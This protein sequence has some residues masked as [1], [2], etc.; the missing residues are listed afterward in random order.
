MKSLSVMIGLLCLFTMN[1]ETAHA[2]SAEAFFKRFQVVRSPDG[3]LIGI[4]DRTLPVKFAVAPYVKQVREQLLDEQSLMNREGL[5]SGKYDSEVKNLLEE[6]MDYSFS[7]NQSDI[8]QNVE[9]VVDSLKKLAVLNVDFIFSHA[10]FQDVV[11][12]FQGKMSDAIMMLDPTMI[13]NVNDSTYFYKRNVTYK[14]VTWGLDFARKSM[15]NLPMLNTVS[16]V[17]VQVEKLITERRQFHQNMLLHYLENFKEEELGLTHD[18]VNMIWSSIYESRIPWYAIWESNAAKADWMKYG[19]NNF[20]AN[21]RAATANLKNAQ[22]LY[23]EVGDRMNFAFQKVTFNNEKVLVNLFDKEGM[24]QNRPAVAYNYDRPTQVARKRVVLQLAGLGLSF[25]PTSSMIKDSVDS[26]IKSYYEQ[27][28]ITE[29][30]LYGLFESNDDAQGK[31]Q[32]VAQYLNPFD[33]LAL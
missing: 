14:A 15:S 29:G 31:E 32:I 28:K 13:A 20:Y 27:Q 10:I 3:K 21:Y 18:E 19:V 26:F 22:T 30:A 7:G 5:T 9:V 33:A 6:G 1:L 25:V 4:R 16:Y 24:F 12:Q 8:D 23:S 2:K 17:I 11:N